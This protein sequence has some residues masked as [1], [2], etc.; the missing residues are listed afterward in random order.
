M[1]TIQENRK[2]NQEIIEKNKKTR[3]KKVDKFTEMTDKIIEK[4]GLK[5]KDFDRQA[6]KEARQK[7]YDD[8]VKENISQLLD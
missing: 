5:S 3:K 6:I 8:F 4:K 7:L 1:E 2:D